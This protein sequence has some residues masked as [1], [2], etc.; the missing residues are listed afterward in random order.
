MKRLFVIL[1]LFCLIAP[2]GGTYLG[3]RI[4]KSHIKKKVKRQIIA[5]I[6][7]DKL[8]VLKFLTKDTADYLRWEHER[9]FEFDDNMY[10]IVER[11]YSNDSV[12]YWC[13][14]DSIETQINT[15]YNIL[16]AQALGNNPQKPD[17]K[18]QLIDY[19][20]V[21]YYSDL[22]S[23]SESRYFLSTDKLYTHYKLFNSSYIITPPG[24]PP[25]SG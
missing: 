15:Q 8:T 21:L 19:L 3:F 9:E 24:P 5:G 20:K 10:D 16:L 4:E 13:W 23:D 17:N 1:L 14:C 7:K 2:F 18:K 6:S 12:T 22:N 25:K 11:K